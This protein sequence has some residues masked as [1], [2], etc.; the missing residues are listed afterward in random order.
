M[1][2]VTLGLRL[3]CL[4]LAAAAVVAG[5]VHHHDAYGLACVYFDFVTDAPLRDCDDE[6]DLP[7]P[8]AAR[9]H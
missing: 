8:A 9:K 4:E 2:D 1:D 7:V 5:R 3:K 6:P